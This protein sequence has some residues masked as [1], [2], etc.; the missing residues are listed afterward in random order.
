MR[1]STGS[2]NTSTSSTGSSVRRST[3]GNTGSTANQT[4]GTQ[5]RRSTS[6]TSSSG[7][8][9]T[10]TARNVRSTNGSAQNV[11][12]GGDNAAV[13]SNTNVTRRGLTT[14]TDDMKNNTQSAPNAAPGG[15]MAPRYDDFRIN[16]H[17][18]ERIHPRERDYI[19][20]TRPGHFYGPDPHYF[21]F[22]IHSLPPR[23]RKVH[24]YGFDY[25]VYNDIYYRPFRGY[26]VICR[27]PVGVIIANAIR[28]AVFAPVR[29]AYYH[30]VYRTYS[31]WD[32]YSRY[33]DQQNRIIAENNAL[34]ARQNSMLAMNTTSAQTSYEIANRLGLAQSYAYANQEYYYDDGVFYILN[35]KGRYEVIVPPAGALV[36]ELPEDY[37]TLTL[38][39]TE[40]YRVDDTVY[41]VVMV[42]GRP[43]L[44]VLG[45]MYGDM[46][47]RYNVLYN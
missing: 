25:Y 30:S 28:D 23:Y 12:N 6:G 8:A 3:T 4:P 36:D 26:Y 14:I 33:I 31:G 7:N 10:Q 38:G 16:N 45:Q 9:T 46:A 40:L 43:C 39:G 24:Y 32:S 21:G 11:Q 41:R 22:R 2:G 15:N 29:F 42:S 44:E 47:R 1:R 17:N 34:I 19:P 13:R 5:V 35:A 27:P 20:Y 37:D 18:V